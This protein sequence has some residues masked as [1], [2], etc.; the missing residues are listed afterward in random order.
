[1]GTLNMH[2][3]ERH[4]VAALSL[5]VLA[6]CATTDTGREI[7]ELPPAALC[8]L[9]DT[10]PS[11]AA[12]AGA[13]P[14]SDTTRNNWVRMIA[15]ELR[16]LDA[17]SRV[18]TRAELGDNAPD[19]VVTLVANRPPQFEHTGASSVL[20]AG[21][22]WITTWIG[23]LLVPD[24]SYR[25]D[26]DATYRLAPTLPSAAAFERRIQTGEVVLSFFERNDFFSGPTL[27]SLIL[28]PFWTTDQADKTNGALEQAAVRTAALEIATFLKRDFERAANTNWRC[29]VEVKQPRNGQPVIGTELNL[30]LAV[31]RART[32]VERVTARL[33]NGPPI[34]L[35]LA[36]DGAGTVAS[37]KLTG[38]RTD[39]ENR[40]R[41]EVVTDKTFTR[42]LRLARA[43]T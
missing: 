6:A 43:G 1:M 23:G 33:I 18:V 11:A 28:P 2:A 8:L 39:V 21:G 42:T 29:S 14:L 4:R 36:P 30:V 15:E 5:S 32:A 9:V 22:L 12:P 41:V 13:T 26:W 27:E 35:S 38:L 40:I 25:L 31:S 3:Q 19:L 24:S 20:L 17:T 16:R 10:Q 37:G 7:R 34:E